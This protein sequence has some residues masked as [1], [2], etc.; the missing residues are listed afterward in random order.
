MGAATC[1]AGG[2]KVAAAAGLI[3][4]KLV[5]GR[6]ATGE[7]EAFG[8][9]IGTVDATITGRA[10]GSGTGWPLRDEDLR[11]AVLA[12]DVPGLDFA[13]FLAGTG[14]AAADVAGFAL[15]A[16][17][18]SAG[19]ATLNASAAIAHPNSWR[20]KQRLKTIPSLRPSRP[21]RP[22]LKK[23]YR[24]GNR[25]AAR[26]VPVTVVRRIPLTNC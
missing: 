25:V 15:S 11:A 5:V 8:G 9:A 17:L 22:R 4:E 19:A 18:A 2:F 26:P 10:R 13:A 14:F 1:A 16:G 20:G 23:F 3:G 7:S 12:A 6:I 24:P 21:C